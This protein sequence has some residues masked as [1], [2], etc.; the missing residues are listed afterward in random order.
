M[1]NYNYGEVLGLSILFYDAQKTGRLPANNRIPWRV[2][3]MYNDRGDN[4]EDLS[5]GYFD[6]II[7]FKLSNFYKF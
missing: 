1:K 4:G 3:A 2:D 7:S 6:G 5:K